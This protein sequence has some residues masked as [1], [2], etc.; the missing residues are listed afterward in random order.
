MEGNEVTSKRPIPSL[1]DKHIDLKASERKEKEREERLKEKHEKTEKE[2]KERGK[3][4]DEERRGEEEEEKKKTRP[5]VEPLVRDRT[6][7]RVRFLKYRK[8][9]ILF[10]IPKK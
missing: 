4:R 10:N 7:R 2:K 6:V 8:L 9:F 3:H 1:F 5:A